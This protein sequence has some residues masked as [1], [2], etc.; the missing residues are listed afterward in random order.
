MTDEFNEIFGRGVTPRPGFTERLKPN[1]QPS[2][3]SPTSETIVGSTPYKPY[4]YLP[5]GTIGEGCDV[6]WWMGS[7][8]TI[9]GIEFQYRFLMQVGYVGDQ[10]LRLFLPD[11]LPPISHPAIT[12]VLS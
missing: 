6:R 3:T 8:E 2:A 11:D 5:S 10:E 1:V 7:T 9:Q 4:G 12:R